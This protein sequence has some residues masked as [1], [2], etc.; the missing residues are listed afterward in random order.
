MNLDPAM[1]ALAKSGLFAAL[2]SA[3]D[4]AGERIKVEITDDQLQAAVDL[5]L[6][7]LSFAIR[8]A[9]RIVK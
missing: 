4:D 3:R 7:Y 8:H 6:D 1:V 2:G 9:P 5:A